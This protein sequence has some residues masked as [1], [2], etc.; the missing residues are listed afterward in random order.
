MSIKE[1]RMKLGMSQSVFA[2]LIGIPVVNIQHWEQGV[3]KPPTY[4]V[5]LIQRVLIAEGYLDATRISVS[6]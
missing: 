3:R 1:M 5:T 6:D 2:N 4:V